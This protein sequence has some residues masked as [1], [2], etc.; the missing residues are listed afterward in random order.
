MKYN[1]FLS[2]N[3]ISALFLFMLQ[4]VLSGSI[5]DDKQ[6]IDNV[7][8]SVVKLECIRI[9]YE[10]QFRKKEY[11]LN[12]GASG[13]GW[14]LSKD[15]Y[16]VT[17][18]HVIENAARISVRTLDGKT[19]DAKVTG[20]CDKTDIA[21]IKIPAVDLRPLEYA[22]MLK[23]S[24]GDEVL[25]VGHPAGQE[26]SLT[27]GIISGLDRSGFY[28]NEIEEYIQTDA[29]IN[30]GNSGGPLVNKS[31]HVVGL[32]S[33]TSRNRQNMGY[34]VSAVLIKKVVGDLKKGI[35]PE[36]SYAGFFLNERNSFFTQKYNIPSG[37]G[38]W[39]SEVVSNSP[40]D[41]AGLKRAMLI[42]HI[43]DAE[44]NNISGI[45]HIKYLQQGT[46]ITIKTADF[47][48]YKAGE[49]LLDVVKRPEKISFS[50]E[51][52]VRM[53]LGA[54]M[55]ERRGFDKGIYIKKILFQ[56]DDKK[57]MNS[58][59]QIKKSLPAL[60]CSINEDVYQID[61]LA[62]LLNNSFVGNGRWMY[63]SLTIT[64]KVNTE[65]Q[66]FVSCPGVVNVY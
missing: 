4:C 62:W 23:V 13:T 35:K 38:L 47:G 11:F 59:M 49:F 19:Y 41:K 33:I 26:Y 34:A 28:M 17:C 43:N 45:K 63:N 51:Q 32:I 16:I 46:P 42:T 50:S 64:D 55:E 18:T 9:G 29:A 24:P 7:K 22:D 15:G 6:L 65:M 31:G 20:S 60:D 58:G 48:Q 54:E 25:A 40:A 66:V 44:A 27:K 3:I 30:P 14:V 61:Q 5:T 37:N 52:T 10:Q 8:A 56:I 21:L 2:M 1:F 57:K 12:K 39:I 53:Y 36:W